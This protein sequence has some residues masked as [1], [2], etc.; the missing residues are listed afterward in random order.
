M[1]KPRGIQ[2]PP[3]YLTDPY[4]ADVDPI[5]K[6]GCTRCAA[7]DQRRTAARVAGLPATAVDA[8]V[9]IWR[10]PH[11]NGKTNGQR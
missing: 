1:S 10:H 11:P 5:P 8:S 3:V 9:E 7:A 2:G 6:P 4:S